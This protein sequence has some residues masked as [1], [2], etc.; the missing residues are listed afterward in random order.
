MKKFYLPMIALSCMLVLD[1]CTSKNP[2]PMDMTKAVQSATTRAD[3]LA[4]AQHYEEAAA[5]AEAK[6]AEHKQLL[7]QYR[8]KSYLYGKEIYNFEEHC[9]ALIHL[10]EQTANSNRKMA[11]MHRKVAQ[12]SP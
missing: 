3:H 7:I 8:Q 1:A 6:V 4:L 2:H 5:A 9:E 11:E 12:A 10:Y